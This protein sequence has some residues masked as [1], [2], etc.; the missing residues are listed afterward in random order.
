MATALQSVLIGDELAFDRDLHAYIDMDQSRRI[1]VTQALKLAGLIDFSMVPPDILANACSRGRLVHD[2]CAI[3][4]R[5]ESLDDVEIPEP[6]MPY[7]EAWMR[8]LS[9]MRFVP[10]PDWVEVPMIVNLFGHRIGMTPDTVG[11]I[12]SILTV[13]ERKA[14]A[15]KHPAWKLQT[16]GYLLGLNASGQQ[17]RQRMAVQLLKTGKYSLDPHED[18][19]DLDTFGD[20]YRVA[21]FKV[22]HRL[23][24][25]DD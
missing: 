23:A 9:D 2:G 3:I 21:A 19:S 12:G 1:S 18:D 25:L 7:L 5:G 16:A 6:V 24:S 10:D 11:T 4:D 17:V 20:V 22:K 8:F 15:S 14:T 13:I